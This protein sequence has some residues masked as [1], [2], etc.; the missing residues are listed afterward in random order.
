ME[1]R[2]FAQRL[3]PI[4]GGGASIPIFTKTLFEVI[5]NEEGK[6]I[7]DDYS[8]STYKQYYKGEIKIGRISR[9]IKPYLNLEGFVTFL[10]EFDSFCATAMERSFADYCPEFPNRDFAEMIAVLF[11]RIINEASQDASKPR[12]TKSSKNEPTVLDAEILE[13]EGIPSSDSKNE[14][15]TV[16]LD[17]QTTIIQNGNNNIAFSSNGVVNINL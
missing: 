8:D 5:V 3:M 14:A 11:V 7:I 13:P 9:R 12:V 10:R 17:N 2:D 6:E 15:K 4:I 1:F 16:N